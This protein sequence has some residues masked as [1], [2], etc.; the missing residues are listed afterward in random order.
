MFWWVACLPAG[1]TMA[2]SQAKHITPAITD[3]WHKVTTNGFKLTWFKRY[4]PASLWHHLSSCVKGTV[5]C[6]FCHVTHILGM[7]IPNNVHRWQQGL[8]SVNN[9]QFMLIFIW[10]TQW[11]QT[12][13]ITWV[14]SQWLLLSWPRHKAPWQVHGRTLCY[15]TIYAKQFMCV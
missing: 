6:F 5:P 10:S 15:F 13:Y 3:S 14:I 4:R 8:A 11:G 7:S 9:A 12:I 2:L 1:R